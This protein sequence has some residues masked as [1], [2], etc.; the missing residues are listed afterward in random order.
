MDGMTCDRNQLMALLAAVRDE[1]CTSQQ[2]A[3]LEGILTKDAAARSVYVQY[4]SI[5]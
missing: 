3:E 5:L 1:D 2:V 4:M